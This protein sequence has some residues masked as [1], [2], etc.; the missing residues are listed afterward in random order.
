MPS[1]TSSSSRSL[2]L[3]AAALIVACAV[4]ALC[5]EL[6]T[7]AALNRSSLTRQRINVQRPRAV[8]LATATDRRTPM[9]IAGNSLFLAGIQTERLQKLSPGLDIAPLFVEATAYYDWY[10]SLR[11]LFREGSRPAVVV[12]G[13]GTGSFLEGGIREDYVAYSMVDRSDLLN[14]AG[15]LDLDRTQT[16]NLLLAHWSQFWGHR[17]VI[18]GRVLNAMIPGLE[19]L[20]RAMNRGRRARMAGGGRASD[21]ALERLTALRDLCRSHSAELVVVIPPTPTPDTLIPV[22]EAAAKS[23]G[24]DFLVPIA[25]GALPRTLYSD[26]SHLDERGAELFT[27]ALANEIGR[28]GAKSGPRQV[29]GVSTPGKA[30]ND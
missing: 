24:I 5:L 26:A 4:V 7:S 8:R 11:A 12:V 21:L 27:Q 29:T 18:R 14:L 17:G 19:D 10:Y 23:A 22:M 20:T 3:W 28:F 9:L 6:G 1:S 13:L 25:P 30:R 15:A 2:K 16:S